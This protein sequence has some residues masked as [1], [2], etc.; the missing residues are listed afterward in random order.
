[1]FRISLIIIIN[2]FITET[3]LASECAAEDFK[4]YVS[5]NI[6]CI[7]LDQATKNSNPSKL[8]IYLHGDAGTKR[9]SNKLHKAAELS[10]NDETLSFL[11]AR[12]GWETPSGHFSNGGDPYGPDNG[13]NYIPERDIDPVAHAIMTLKNHYKPK[14]VIV[15]GFSGG[16]AIAGV[17]LGRYP[18]LINI[19]VLSSCPCIV[20]P[21]REH[22]MK[23]K[24]QIEPS[25]KI[26]WP[27]SHS[28]H[29]YVVN[30]NKK[31]KIILVVGDLDTNT[32]PEYSKIYINKLVKHSIDSQLHV[33]KG[34][35]H[36]D[37]RTNNEYI[38]LLAKIQREY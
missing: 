35:G 33:I 8:V 27:N 7:G 6:G 2:L 9:I 22:R 37:I 14:T 3:A 21:W 10:G 13:D 4:N 12:P 18:D 31:A 38:E 29:D 20:P 28:P 1:M 16:A 17:I 15:V 19:A 32:K 11:M 26:W 5:S 25:G 34:A 23:Q 30:I 36:A 24:K